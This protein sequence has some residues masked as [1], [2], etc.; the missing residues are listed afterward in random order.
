M[1]T[2]TD[3]TAEGLFSTLKLV[4][5]AG[6]V[7]SALAFAA[8]WSCLF[9]YYNE[10]GL[11]LFDLDLQFPSAAIFSIKVLLK[12][13]WPW[14]A[15][16]A[17]LVGYGLT[18]RLSVFQTARPW[19]RDILIFAELLGSA[20]LMALAGVSVGHASA[21]A[22]TNVATTELPTVAFISKFKADYQLPSCFVYNT[23]DCRM[24]I[25]AKGYYFF[26]EPIS[27]DAQPGNIIVYSVPDAQVEIVRLERGLK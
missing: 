27:A 22:D 7:L 13:V 23:L 15:F 5:E 14:I 8:G 17:G 20:I 18:R 26:F 11:G 24:L 12:S 1:N 25:H 19:L 6:A 2:T 9:A 3:T 21:L 16:I 4:V 10:F